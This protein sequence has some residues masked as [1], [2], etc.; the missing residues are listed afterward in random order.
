MKLH[1]QISEGFCTWILKEGIEIE[2]DNYPE[3]AGKS[4]EEVLQYI[5][6]KSFKMKS[7]EGDDPESYSLFDELMDQETIV[8]KE[9]NYETEVQFEKDR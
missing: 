2:T 9:T 4:K 6:T 5:Q 8:N 3:L 7:T 1:I